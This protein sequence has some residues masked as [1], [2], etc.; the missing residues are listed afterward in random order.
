MF[1]QIV[2]LYLFIVTF[3]ASFGQ[4]SINVLHFDTVDIAY[5]NETKTSTAFPSASLALDI[6]RTKSTFVS[7]YSVTF[8]LVPVS[9][10]EIMFGQAFDEFYTKTLDSTGPKYIALLG[11]RDPLLSEIMIE[12]ANRFHK[13]ISVSI[14]FYYNVLLHCKNFA[15]FHNVLQ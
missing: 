2:I 14:I 15:H 10:T 13:M 5:G 9:P 11:P 6:Y 8:T 7:D 1:Q 12:V 3:R 4:T